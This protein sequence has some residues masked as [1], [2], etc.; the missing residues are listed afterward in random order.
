MRSTKRFESDQLSWEPSRGAAGGP[1]PAQ[2]ASTGRPSLGV[3]CAC[4]TFA[5]ARGLGRSV[6]FRNLRSLRAFVRSS[7][8]GPPFPRVSG[9]HARSGAPS[10]HLRPVALPHRPLSRRVGRTASGSEIRGESR[11]PTW[12]S[13]TLPEVAGEETFDRSP[14]F[15]MWGRKL[16]SGGSLPPLHFHV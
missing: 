16:P 13:W 15:L 2:P 9:R 10:P 12:K 6:L 11:P 5:P 3:A 8:G 1:L 4:S 14:L 7:R